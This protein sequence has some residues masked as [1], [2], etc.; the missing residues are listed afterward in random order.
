MYADKFPSAKLSRGLL[1]VMRIITADRNK[2]DRKLTKKD[3][4]ILICQLFA[5][6]LPPSGSGLQLSNR[7]MIVRR[8][9]Q[10]IAIRNVSSQVM[11]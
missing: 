2:Q 1:F 7:A 3:P 8:R 11:R 10:H 6:L 5:F 9:G 4:K